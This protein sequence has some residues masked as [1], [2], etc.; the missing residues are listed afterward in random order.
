MNRLSMVR[1]G[2]LPISLL[3]AIAGVGCG[4]G[5]GG[6]VDMGRDLG[7]NDQ[8]QPVDNGTQD[9]GVDVGVDMGPNLPAPQVRVVHAVSDLLTSNNVPISGIRLCVEVTGLG[10]IAL[11]PNADVLE[12]IDLRLGLPFRAVTPYQETLPP[13]TVRVYDEARVDN[14]MQGA[15]P[16]AVNCPM[17]GLDADCTDDTVPCLF[18][19]AFDPTAL[20]DGNS[21]S[22]VVSGFRDN[23]NTCLAG[24]VPCPTGAISATL[25]QDEDVDDVV[26]GSARVRFVHSIHNL[27]PADLC[28]DLDGLAMNAAAPTL[29]HGAVATG[30]ITGY[31]TVPPVTTGMVF[32]TLKNPLDASTLT[33][34]CALSTTPAA[35]GLPSNV[36]P[37][38]FSPANAMAMPPDVT[39]SIT[40]GTIITVY[41]MGDAR[42]LTPPAMPPQ[43][44]PAG[45][46]NYAGRTPL[47]LSF[48]DYAPAP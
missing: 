21:Y 23:T 16:P 7:G 18:D 34:N 44:D 20:E 40:A 15:I 38:F 26:A 12:E 19:F 9:E 32:L 17:T 27:P 47:V 31:A 39:P 35:S 13:S 3:L 6:M 2:F 22:L 36:V 46:A 1:G 30:D 42:F 43:D 29:I 25:E 41:A 10:V 24:T 5:D 14:D 37:V 45:W 48:V 33:G 28:Y 11:P 8:G 4:D